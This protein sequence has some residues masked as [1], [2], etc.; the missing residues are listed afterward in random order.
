MSGR[1]GVGAHDMLA[2]RHNAVHQWA[3]ASAARGQSA[4]LRC[5][6]QV[7][8]RVAGCWI[9]DTRWCDS[10]RDMIEI[11]VKTVALC[12]LRSANQGTRGPGPGKH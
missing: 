6:V 11:V 2:F 7:C 3:V 1:R 4:T 9:L 8:K 5:A 10:F 12:A